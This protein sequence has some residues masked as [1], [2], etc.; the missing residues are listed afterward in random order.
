MG[1]RRRLVVVNKFLVVDNESQGKA[2]N[3]Q[4]GLT[5]AIIGLPGGGTSRKTEYSMCLSYPFK[6]T[7]DKQSVDCACMSQGSIQN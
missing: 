7:V 6:K 5:L 4:D 1:P 2:F 3:A